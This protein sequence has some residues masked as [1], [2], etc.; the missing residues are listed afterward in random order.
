MKKIL[1]ILTTAVMLFAF[2]GCGISGGSEGT[3]AE[4]N[5]G[6]SSEET[7]LLNGDTLELSYETHHKDMYFKANIVDF[8]TDTAGALTTLTYMQNG[9]VAYRI[10]I[11]YFEG[12]SIE[13]AMGDSAS[14]LTDKT[15][16]GI[17]YKYLET[18]IEYTDKT[19]P[20]HVYVYNFENTTYTINFIS[21]YDMSSLETGFF[22]TVRF[23]KSE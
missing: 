23:E 8:Y 20:A 4:N 22:N 9:D 3:K 17:A 10:N 5:N 11:L 12:K 13:E 14:L 15:V 2:A 19:V 18:N 7:V 6:K 16:N 21:E 1:A